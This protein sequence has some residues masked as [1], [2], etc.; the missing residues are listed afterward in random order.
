MATK[1]AVHYSTRINRETVYFTEQDFSGRKGDS[2]SVDAQCEDCGGFLFIVTG[3]L[4]FKC[5]GR[6]EDRDEHGEY[7]ENPVR[8]EGCGATYRAEPANCPI[9]IYDF[10]HCWDCNPL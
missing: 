7:L 5:D 1:T 8:I 9:E 4:T 10:G 3:W 6:E 2:I